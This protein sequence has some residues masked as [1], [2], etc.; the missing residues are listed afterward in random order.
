MKYQ[1]EVTETLQ[2][3]VEIE[4]DSADEAVTQAAQDY[5]YGYIKLNDKDLKGFEIKEYKER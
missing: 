5:A 1:I 4:A 2:R 3:I